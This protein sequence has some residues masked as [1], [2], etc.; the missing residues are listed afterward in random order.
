MVYF[1]RHGLTDWN[2]NRDSDGNLAPK[3]QG[4]V[5]I[6]LNQ[7]GIAQAQSLKQQLKDVKFD[8]VYCSPLSRAKQTCEIIV[9]NLNTVIIDNRVIERD[10]GEFEGKTRDDFNFQEFCKEK[11]DYKYN[12]SESV[13][14]VRERVFGFLDELRQEPDKNV[15]IVSHGG[16]G[17]LFLAYFDGLPE[18]GDYSNL[19]IPNGKPVIREFKG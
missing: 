17:C 18:D 7:N 6:P 13:K 4:H 2:E 1:V 11:Y 16:I 10:F 15:L 5:D 19:L 9:G 14:N 3:C 12:K 8:K